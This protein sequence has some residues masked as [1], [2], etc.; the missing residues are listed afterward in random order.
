MPHR[1][2]HG[3]SLLLFN[4]DNWRIL[5]CGI[6]NATNDDHARANAIL[7]SIFCFC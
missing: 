3:H 7:F 2:E 5:D 6:H 4:L 1:L